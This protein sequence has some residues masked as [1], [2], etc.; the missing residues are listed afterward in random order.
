MAEHGSEPGDVLREWERTV[1]GPELHAREPFTTLDGTAD[2]TTIEAAIRLKQASAPCS[3]LK[4]ARTS[5]VRRQ[6]GLS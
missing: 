2:L 3:F 5:R 6:R 4:I 1:H